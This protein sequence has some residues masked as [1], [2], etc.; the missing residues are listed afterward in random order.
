MSE[1]AATRTKRLTT[2]QAW[3]A[4]GI[5]MVAY[6][7]SFI[8]RSILSLMVAPVRRDLGIS[9]TQFGLLHGLAFAV[10]YTALGIPIAR[11]AD[12]Y[13]RRWLIAIGVFVW[14]LATV[15]CGLAKNF[16]QLFAARIGV[17]VGEASLSPA[18]YSM[19]ADMFPKEMLGRALSVYNVGVFLGGGLALIIGGFVVAAV[20]EAN[21]YTLPLLGELRGWQLTF[22][23]V[24]LPG[25]LIALLTLTLRE[26]PRPTADKSEVS[27][28]IPLVRVLGFLWQNR[29]TFAMHFI[30]FS[31]L[32]LLY[33]SVFAWSPALLSRRFGV[34][35][36]DTGLYLGS[37]VLLFAT[38][39]I[40]AGGW[41]TDWQ[42]R[43]GKTDA[44][45][46]TGLVAALALIPL[47]TIAPLMPSLPLTLAIYC[48]LMFF[49]SFPWAA[50]AAALQIISPP[51]MRA[52][53]SACYLFIVN[54]AGIGCGPVLT[55]LV[56]DYV[57][58][59]DAALPYSLVVVGSISAIISALFL[60]RGMGHFRASLSTQGN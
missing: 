13:S 60:A 43:R 47:I 24:G 51:R 9:D 12:R 52:Q 59:D 11:L 28:S 40:L 45:L 21:L 58:K 19:I 39:G 10:F 49:I 50:A 16:G 8:D 32:A 7:F 33:N 38:T 46:R 36:G 4:V 5:L 37:I 34:S 57:F 26:P 15:L 22:V 18:A 23:I 42:S 25:I 48:P 31:A 30:G 27:E 55:A 2:K 44:T 56:T 6:T 20:G 35:G 14:S 53:V 1:P 29:K 3:Y 54:L 41:Y 17:G